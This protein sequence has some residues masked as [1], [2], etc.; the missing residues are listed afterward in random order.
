MSSAYLSDDANLL[1][2][3]A[4]IRGDD[5]A[6]F[7]AY[8][9]LRIEAAFIGRLFVVYKPTGLNKSGAHKDPE[10]L[11]TLR[12][13]DFRADADTGCQVRLSDLTSG[14]EMTVDHV[15]RRVFHYDLFMQV[16]P[17]LK[18]RWSARVVDGSVSR[19]L[20]FAVLVKTKNRSDFY[21][22]RNTYCETPNRFRDLFP[23][24][25]YQP[26]FI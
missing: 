6:V 20:A 2:L 22:A 1:D 7:R 15:P 4:H 23:R 18:L 9:H 17:L 8:G 3:E 26:Q 13:V 16:P 19:N 5:R 25:D 21:S 14:E 24:F 11:T 10:V 12:V